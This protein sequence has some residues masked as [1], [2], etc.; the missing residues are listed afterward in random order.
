MVEVVGEHLIS[1][2][3]VHLKKEYAKMIAK[4]NVRTISCEIIP[5]KKVK[6]GTINRNRIVRNTSV[7]SNGEEFLTSILN[8]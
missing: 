8:S 1:G 2:A 7:K 3:I 4:T 6:A 5:S